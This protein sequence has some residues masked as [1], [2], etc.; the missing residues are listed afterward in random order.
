MQNFFKEQINDLNADHLKFEVE[1]RE[2]AF[3]KDLKVTSKY[4]NE[5]NPFKYKA[6]VR[7]DNQE[8]ISVVGN[9]YEPQ[10]FFDLVEKQQ[11]GLEKAGLLKGN[12]ICRDYMF[13]GS[14]KFRRDIILKDLTIEPRKG[15]IVNFR[16]SC[17]SSHDGSWSTTG[18]CTPER[19]ACLNGMVQ[20]VWNVIHK[21]RHTQNFYIDDLKTYFK[22]CAQHFNEM[23]P[24]FKK[25]GN[26]GVK[27]HDVASELKRALC[28]RNP[29]KR[30]KSN[31]N[32]K[33]YEWLMHTFD[34]ESKD[35]GTTLW[36]FYNTLTHW[37]SHPEQYDYKDDTKLYNVSKDNEQKIL[38]FI[39]NSNLFRPLPNA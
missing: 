31:Y 22:I 25:M 39:K 8:F 6:L 11:E 1:L 32:E 14:A 30:N 9:R 7:K 26:I 23:E 19:L 27:R 4:T 21:F 5:I 37:S 36:A 2:M 12:F 16:S 29:S 15:D 38:V 35:L 24:Y 33:L 10:N 28:K 3:K 34:V 13:E 20:P 17:S 18:N